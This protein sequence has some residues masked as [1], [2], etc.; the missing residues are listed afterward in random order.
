MKVLVT[1]HAQMF[2]TPDGAVWTN[3]VYGY[4]FFNRYLDVFD[5][6]RLVTRMKDISYDE[7]GKRIRVDGNGVEF[8]PL[9]FY[10]G[11]WEYFYN[12]Y[13]IQSKFSYAISGCDC[14]ILR[15]PDQMAFQLFNNIQKKNIPCAIEVVAHSWDLYAPGTIKTIVRPVLRVLWD[16]LQKRACKKANGVAYVTEK[17]IQK[18]YPSNIG[19][20][21][22]DRFETFYTSA[23]LNDVFFD[24]PRKVNEFNNDIL[25]LVHVAGVNNS[26]KG[27]YELLHALSAIKEKGR[28]VKATFVG[29]GTMLDYYKELSVKLGLSAEV[30]F[31]GHISNT[32]DIANILKK[33]DIFVLPTKTEGLPRVI[34][35]AMA[36]G[37]P[38]IATRVGGIPELIS[39]R[40]LVD[41]NDIESLEK[42][43]LEFIVDKGALVEESNKNF[44]KA[45]QYSSEVI[46]RKRKKFYSD[47]RN[48]ANY[49]KA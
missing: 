34:L 39:E 35:E 27:H 13:R 44:N 6:V 28:T 21:N 41:L 1:T 38:C 16:L 33:S 47:L 10:H 37:I 48:H 31:L 24:R 49:I 11:P 43:I 36:M 23:D 7:V 15:I 4:S 3:S 17:Y 30:T 20:I 18:R 14:A 29:G 9:P 5:T 42:K 25:T 32:Q 22:K 26:A 12:L 8:F 45:R 46:Q 40:C 2:R 19:N